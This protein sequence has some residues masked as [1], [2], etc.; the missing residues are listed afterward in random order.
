MW[1]RFVGLAVLFAPVGGFLGCGVPGMF[2][3]CFGVPVFPKVASNGGLPPPDPEPLVVA[4][5][6]VLGLLAC[7]LLKVPKTQDVG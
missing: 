6:T 4:L 7:Q 5:V 1:F 3:V 2:V